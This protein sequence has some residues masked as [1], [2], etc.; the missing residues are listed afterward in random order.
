MIPTSIVKM[1]IVY[2]LFIMA[3][4]F[5]FSVFIECS[6]NIY[7]KPVFSMPLQ[8]TVMTTRRILERIAVHHVSRRMAWKILKGN[9][10]RKKNVF[11]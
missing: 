8:S 3:H 10:Y 4:H 6:S 2:I 9:Y 7:W 11:T 1:L 5:A